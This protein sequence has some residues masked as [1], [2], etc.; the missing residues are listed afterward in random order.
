MAI[1]ILFAIVSI[2]VLVAALVRIAREENRAAI[3]PRIYLGRGFQ[4][5]E[6]RIK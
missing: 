3:K 4:E 5:L 2:W 6:R 1:N